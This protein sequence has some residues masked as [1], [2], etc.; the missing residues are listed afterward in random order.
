MNKDKFFEIELQKELYYYENDG[1]ATYVPLRKGRIE[2]GVYNDRDYISTING[3]RRFNV[4]VEMFCHFF[5]DD[6][7]YIKVDIFDSETNN[8]ISWLKINSKVNK[9]SITQMKDI[10]DEI[11]GVLSDESVENK[12]VE[13]HKLLD[14]KSIFIEQVKKK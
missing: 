3:T 11:K 14:E 8:C 12:L 13:M 2:D 10:A 1:E 5:T 9:L 6:D 4:R 7:G